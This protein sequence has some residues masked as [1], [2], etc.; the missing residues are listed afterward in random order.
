MEFPFLLTKEKK[1]NC[2]KFQHVLPLQSPWVSWDCVPISQQNLV[3]QT[4]IQSPD[5]DE[6]DDAC[7]CRQEFFQDFRRVL[8]NYNE[9]WGPPRPQALPTPSF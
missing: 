5:S 8:K 3:I 1:K 9:M 4:G 7:S 6:T 2:L